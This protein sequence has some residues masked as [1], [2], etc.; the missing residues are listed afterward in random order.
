[1]RFPRKIQLIILIVILIRIESNLKQAHIK[2]I[3]V[4]MHWVPSFDYR[5][6]RNAFDVNRYC[7]WKSK[8]TYAE[9]TCYFSSTPCSQWMPTKTTRYDIVVNWVVYYNRNRLTERS[10]CLINRV[11]VVHVTTRHGYLHIAEAA[12]RPAAEASKTENARL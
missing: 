3:Y 4:E 8:R 12:P 5:Y 1:M 7:E 10:R 9:A 11:C 6:R 2:E